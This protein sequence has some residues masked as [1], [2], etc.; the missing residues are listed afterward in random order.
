MWQQGCQVEGASCPCPQLPLLRRTG[1]R[2][3]ALGHAWVSSQIGKDLVPTSADL[4]SMREVNLL[5]LTSGKIQT[6]GEIQSVP[7]EGSQDDWRGI[8]G[9]G[10]LS[11]I[12][13]AGLFP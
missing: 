12:L 4:L 6:H 2:E 7:S 9:I 11:T 5:F 1:P 13:M 3:G 10:H 8:Q